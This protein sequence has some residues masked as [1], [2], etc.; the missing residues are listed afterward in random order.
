MDIAG[1]V[2][3]ADRFNHT[4][5]QV[6]ATGVV[7]TLAGLAPASGSSDGAGNEAR[8]SNARGMTADSVGNLY[9]ADTWNH[10]IRKVTPAAVVTTLAGLAGVSGS[11]DGAGSAAQFY[12]PSGVAVGSAGNLFVADWFNNTIRKVTP[13]GIVTTLAGLAGTSGTSD[14][15]GGAAR[16]YHPYGVAAD[17]VGNV[18]ATDCN[19]CTIRKVTSGGVVTTLAGLAGASGSTDGTGSGARF[20]YPYAV[21][22]DGVG[23]VYVADSANNTIRKVTPAGV[24]TTL[25]GLAKSSGSSDGMGSEA[26]FYNPSGVAV[27]SEN[28]VYV[29]D[30]FNYTI[31]KVTA[32][33]VVTTIGG[34]PGIAGGVDGVG[35]SANFSY[36]SAVAVGTNGSLYVA[37]AYNNRISKGTPHVTGDISGDGYVNVPDL[38]ALVTAWGSHGDGTPSSNWNLAA[39]LNIDGYVNV[40]D[41]Q[42]LVANWGRSM[43]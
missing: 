27:D 29:A 8:F 34:A 39:D 32:N 3:V 16:F 2:Y 15:T 21:A 41:L 23:N 43:Y 5:R 7:T 1:N 24:V 20:N 38:Q 30:T 10:T 13:D 4:I 11:S 9:V 35:T 18:Y 19:N 22:A 37:D 31:R 12:R 25:A 6:T 33:G 17:S 42:M 28:N 14:G 40:G 36:P 26:R